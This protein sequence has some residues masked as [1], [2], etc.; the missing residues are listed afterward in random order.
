MI[1]KTEAKEARKNE[2]DGEPGRR[3]M[4]MMMMKK[5][6]EITKNEMKINFLKCES[7]VK[8]MRK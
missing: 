7:K 5:K 4:M 8:E 6:I 2:N 3:M 1:R